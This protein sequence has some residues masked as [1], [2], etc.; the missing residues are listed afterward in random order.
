MLVGNRDPE[1]AEE[2]RQTPR[3]TKGEEERGVYCARSATRPRGQRVWSR[4]VPDACAAKPDFGA[5]AAGA[6]G[7]PQV[8]DP[9]AGHTGPRLRRGSDSDMEVGAGIGAARATGYRAAKPTI[10]R[11]RRAPHERLRANA[12]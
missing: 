10:A 11:V 6:H 8:L 3:P 9:V 7:A 1:A 12:F 2:R 4:P 5:G